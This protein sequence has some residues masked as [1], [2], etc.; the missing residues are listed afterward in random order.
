MNS[1]GN[2][3]SRSHSKWRVSNDRA[4]AQSILRGGPCL[5]AFLRFLRGK[6]KANDSTFVLMLPPDRAIALT[7]GKLLTTA[8]LP[9][10]ESNSANNTVAE[11]TR[12]PQDP[13]VLGLMNRSLRP[14]I[15]LQAGGDRKKVEP[16]PERSSGK[17]REDSVWNKDRRDSSAEDR[18]AERP[19]SGKPAVGAVRQLARSERRAAG[20]TGALAGWVASRHGTYN[21]SA[22]LLVGISNARQRHDDAG[23]GRLCWSLWPRRPLSGRLSIWATRI[24]DDT[25]LPRRSCTTKTG[26]ISV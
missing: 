4:I 26:A 24:F 13:K 6:W 7:V 25:C 11:V 14:W 12:H 17:P 18:R 15:V 1:S 8:D 19:R 5:G 2:D 3:A 21:P 20:K 23:L 16:G 10:T 22:R 9:G